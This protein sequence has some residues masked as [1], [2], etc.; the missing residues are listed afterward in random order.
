MSVSLCICNDSLITIK[1][2]LAVTFTSCLLL[3]VRDPS[4]QV[5]ILCGEA[6]TTGQQRR[7]LINQHEDNLVPS[8]SQ[9]ETDTF[10]SVE[11]R[12]PSAISSLVRVGHT[13]IEEVDTKWTYHISQ[14]V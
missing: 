6:G 13:H 14:M 7:R 5:Q 2:R 11:M 8:S 3:K 10:T 12:D 1:S 4:T 9:T